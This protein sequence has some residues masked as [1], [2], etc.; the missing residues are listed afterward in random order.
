MT[1]EIIVSLAIDLTK[2]MGIDDPNR[3]Y[4]VSEMASGDVL[5]AATGVTDGSLL[6]GVRVRKNHVMTSTIVMRS[7]SQTVRWINARHAR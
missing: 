6:N 1:A 2:R 4:N 3:K 7:W 5:F